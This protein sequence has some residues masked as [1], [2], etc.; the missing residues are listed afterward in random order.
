MNG[1]PPA[2]RGLLQLLRGSSPDPPLAENQQRSLFDLADR[3]HC[4]LYI[5][6]DK[7]ACLTL[8]KN[9]ERRRRLW[10][11][12]D[13]AAAAL[14]GH[15][16]DFVLLKGFTHEAD[17]GIDPARRYQSDLDFLCLPAEIAGARAALQQAGYYEHGSAELSD[18]HARPL[19]KPFTWRWRGDYFDPD[20]P[21]SIELHHTLWSRSRDRID[22]PNVHQSWSRRTVL[23]TE[24]RAIPALAEAD[25]IAFA[26]LHVLRHILRNHASPSHTFELACTLN[27]LADDEAF[28]EVWMRSHDIQFRALQAIAFEFARRW[29]ACTLSKAAESE[30]RALPAPIQAWFRSYAFSPV[31]N[32]VE[33]NKDA[34]WLHMALLPRRMDRFAVG[35]QKLLPLRLPRPTERDERLG[36]IRYHAVA[37]ARALRTGSRRRRTAPSTASQTSD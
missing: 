15:G 18:D 20:L 10:Q 11:A 21:I 6:S 30:C 28:W 31:V 8:A 34:L 7:I 5:A 13:E 36:R 26:A 33:P 1:L 14:S 27:R 4:T 12:Y 23:S 22:V 24:G 17:S 37:L 2:V 16:I 3:T 19:V 25:R 29:F 32:L 9:A 35:V